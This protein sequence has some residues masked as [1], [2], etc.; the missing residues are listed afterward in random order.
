[1]TSRS[2]LLCLVLLLQSCSSVNLVEHW[3]NPDIVLFHAHKV[4]VVGLSSD[5]TARERFEGLMVKELNEREVAAM[6]SVDLFDIE[7]TTAVAS[8]KELDLV[9]QQ[10][11]ERD[12]DAILFTKVVGVE[13]HRTFRQQ[14]RDVDSYYQTFS[15]NYLWSRDQV[16]D[17]EME[18]NFPVYHVETSLYCICPTK[19][20]ELIWRV[21]VDVTDPRDI[22]QVIDDYVRL[23]ITSMEEQDIILYK[24]IP[25]ES[26]S[27]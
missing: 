6:R 7:F 10:L 23:L 9:E 15:E 26:T 3:K 13:N 1:M 2:L 27:L 8:E 5:D 11:I 25:D 24:P 18:Q 19:D 14:L 21:L 22:N 4:L 16:L 20:R 17:Q 12:F